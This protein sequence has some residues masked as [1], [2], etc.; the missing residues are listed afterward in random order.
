[1]GPSHVVWWAVLCTHLWHELMSCQSEDEVLWWHIVLCRL[2][3]MWGNINLGCLLTPNTRRTALSLGI[4][5]ANTVLLQLFSQPVK[6]LSSLNHSATL[7]GTAIRGMILIRFLKRFLCTMKEKAFWL[8]FIL[9]SDS[10]NKL[11][12]YHL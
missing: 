1:M 2:T 11:N 6:L 4:Q 5:I 10:F 9:K 7:W 12:Q 8:P 3:H